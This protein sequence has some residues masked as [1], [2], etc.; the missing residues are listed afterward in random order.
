[1][2]VQRELSP[3]EKRLIEREFTARQEAAAQQRHFCRAVFFAGIASGIVAAALRSFHVLTV[4]GAGFGVCWLVCA[5][6]YVGAQ[7]LPSTFAKD[8]DI[9]W[10]MN[11][12]PESLRSLF[13]GRT[14]A[15]AIALLAAPTVAK[16]IFAFLYLGLK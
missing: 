7:I 8:M 14:I 4:I 9:R 11:P 10:H 3:E 5:V 13:A 2:T 12:W 1:M 6:I 16:F 15:E